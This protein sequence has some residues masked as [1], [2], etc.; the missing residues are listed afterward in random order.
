VKNIYRL[1]IV[2][3]LLLLMGCSSNYTIKDFPSKDKFYQSFNTSVGYKDIDITLTDNSQVTK[4]GGGILKQ[5]TLYT[6]TDAFPVETIKN[7]N[8]RTKGGGGSVLV[9]ILSGVIIGGIVAL[10][11]YKS[12]Q[13]LGDNEGPD[14]FYDFVVI[15]TGALFGGITGYYFGWETTYLFNP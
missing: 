6:L 2:L 11:T 3:A 1:S 10:L 7:I 13:R 9:G 5:D 4:F 14:G 15:G 12:I 8:Y